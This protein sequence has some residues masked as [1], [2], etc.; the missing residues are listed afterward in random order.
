M[1]K[2]SHRLHIFLLITLLP[3]LIFAQNPLS[4]S[5]GK[6][7][8]KEIGA[9]II[10]QKESEK[11]LITVDSLA[12]LFENESRE[13]LQTVFKANLDSIPNV[14]C[15]E[16]PD[17]TFKLISFALQLKAQTF[18]YY[19]FILLPTGTLYKLSSKQ[20]EE[21]LLQTSTLNADEWFGAIYYRIIL[22]EKKEKKYYT[23][24][25]WNGDGYKYQRKVIE[26]LHFTERET[27]IFG[28]PI[29]SNKPI[30]QRIIFYYK[31]DVTMTL[32]YSDQLYF[33]K[34]RKKELLREMIV[35]DYLMPLYGAV[36]D[37]RSHNVPT[38]SYDAYIWESGIWKYI[39]DI[40]AK[41]SEKP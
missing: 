33:D 13:S 3:S 32:Q 12:L 6:E 26:V 19:G 40:N 15:L 31:K 4:K 9:A 38:F 27:P 7:L 18:K 21:R 30:N 22:T 2:T 37:S 10:S 25:G 17:H 35:F 34:K 28:A 39:D 20:H 29:F 1:L 16:A 14:S 5:S 8:L 23:L 24:L 11:Q 36:G 41:N